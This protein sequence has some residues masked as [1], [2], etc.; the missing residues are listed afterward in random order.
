M[1]SCPSP[2][3]LAAT[4]APPA[5]GGAHAA[6]DIVAGHLLATRPGDHEDSEWVL[7][8]LRAA[9]ARARERGAPG[10]AAALLRRALDEPLPAETSTPSW[11]SSAGRRR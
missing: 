9:V 2:S 3:A 11:P 1:G 10:A 8:A 6:D 4:R 7:R 5:A